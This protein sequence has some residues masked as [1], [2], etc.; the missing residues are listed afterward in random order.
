M[1]LYCLNKFN[2]ICTVENIGNR[3]KIGFMLS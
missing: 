3:L 1:I 2:N